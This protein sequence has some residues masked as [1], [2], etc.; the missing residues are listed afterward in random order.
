MSYSPSQ[1]ANISTPK[2]KVIT[3]TSATE[4]ATNVDTQVN[5]LVKQFRLPAQGQTLGNVV[6]DS[7]KIWPQTSTVVN[8]VVTFQASVTWN[9]WVTP[10]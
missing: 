5:T 3:G 2:I 4:L 7:I 8:N 10:S 9:Q 1:Q 6:N